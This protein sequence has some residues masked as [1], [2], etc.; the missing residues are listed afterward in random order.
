M[1]VPVEAFIGSFLADVTYGVA[2]AF[3]GAQCASLTDVNSGGGAGPLAVE[4]VAVGVGIVMR[5]AGSSPRAGTSRR[6]VWR[7]SRSGV[8]RR[9]EKRNVPG[10]RRTAR[11][12]QLA[13]EE[14]PSPSAGSCAARA[15]FPRTWRGM[16]DRSG[17]ARGWRAVRPRVGSARAALREPYRLPEGEVQPWTT[18]TRHVLSDG[19]V[20]CARAPTPAHVSITHTRHTERRQKNTKTQTHKHGARRRIRKPAAVRPASPP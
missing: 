1:P 13:G 3:V 7:R 15:P 10:R 9:D 8:A 19:L 6:E 16:G 20:A 17:R 4:Y 11:G 18:W 12:D 2:Y 5:R 14:A